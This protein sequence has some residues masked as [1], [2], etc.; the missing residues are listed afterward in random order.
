MFIQD[1]TTV[2]MVYLI[3]TFQSNDPFCGV[4]AHHQNGKAKCRSQD[5]TEGAR[6]TLIHA[7]DCWPKAIDVSLLPAARHNY[8]N[9][10]NNIPT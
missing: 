3:V 7:S 6:I 1:I 8:I 10:R 5:V 9:I 4:N 2:T